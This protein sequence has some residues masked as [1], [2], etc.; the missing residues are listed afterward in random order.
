MEPRPLDW[1]FSLILALDQKIF[2]TRSKVFIIFGTR[3]NV[4]I[5]VFLASKT[6]DLVPK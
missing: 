4:L 1:K 5:M 2:F 6:F 3:S